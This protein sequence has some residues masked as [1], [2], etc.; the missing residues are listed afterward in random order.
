MKTVWTKDLKT[1]EL[2]DEFKASFVAS[3]KVRQRLSA[4]LA[5][6]LKTNDTKRR[7]EEGYD[8]PSWSL[9]QADSIGYE[10]AIEEIISILN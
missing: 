9:K 2:K 5:E 10:R 4:I 6:K 8:S 3:A 7:S 1:Q